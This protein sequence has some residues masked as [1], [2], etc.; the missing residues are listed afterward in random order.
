V[1]EIEE[2]RERERGGERELERA[3]ANTL[4]YFAPYLLTNIKA[5]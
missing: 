5:F 4:A 3:K 1:C 2:E